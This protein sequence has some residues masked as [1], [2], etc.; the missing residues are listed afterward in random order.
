MQKDNKELWYKNSKKRWQKAEAT[1]HGIM[2]GFTDVNKSDIDFSCALLQNLIDVK[3]INHATAIDC[4]AGIGRVSENVLQKFF[5]K[6]DIVERDEK[7]IEACK[8][9]FAGNKKIRN[10]FCDSLQNFD[11]KNNYD[12]MWMQWCV[13][14]IIHEDL[15]IFLQKCAEALTPNG[16]III[17]ENI[18]ND[19][20]PFLEDKNRELRSVQYFGEIFKECNLNLINYYI[21]PNWPQDLLRVAT[22]ILQAK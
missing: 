20:T 19:D 14:E 4:A 9:T 5:D 1:L 13:D 3:K 18:L 12:L 17:K 15:I 7:F 10:I 6:I 21:Q 16:I 2:D 22:F 8:K 11:F